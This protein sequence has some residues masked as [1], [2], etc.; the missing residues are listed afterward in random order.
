MR[1]SIGRYAVGALAVGGASAALLISG[2]LTT[3]SSAASNRLPAA[4]SP[5]ATFRPYTPATRPKPSNQPR[6]AGKAGA[7]NP[8]LHLVNAP[9]SG[10]VPGSMN[11]L[12]NG[13]VLIHE[14]NTR[15]WE[16][17]TPDS[18][19][20]YVNGTWSS[21]GST[22][23]G[24]APLY[25]ASQV[26]PTGKLIIEGGEYNGSNSE[27]WTTLGA[28][29]N[30]TTNS[31]A[32]VSPPSTWRNMG[33]AQSVMLPTRT[34]GKMLLAHPFADGSGNTGRD[35]AILNGN[36]SWT[37]I[38]GTGK[39]DRNDEEGWTLLPNNKVL[40]VD[41]ENNWNG[42]SGSTCSPCTS[43]LFNRSTNTWSATGTVPVDLPS[44]V[45]PSGPSEEMGPVVMRPNG[46]AFAI[47]GNDATASYHVGT[48]TWTAGPTLANNY[49]S[50]DGSASIL[51]NGDVLLDASPGVFNSPTH[52]YVSNG[53]TMTQVA[54][55][56][57]APSDSSYVTRMIVLPTGQVMVDDGTGDIEIFNQDLTYNASWAPTISSVSST[58]LAPGTTY[59]VSGTQLSGRSGGAAYGDDNQS[60]TNYPLVR[61]TNTSTGTVTYATTSG[62]SYAITSGAASQTS[63]VVPA[64][65]PAGNYT[66]QVVAN[67]IPSTGTAVTVS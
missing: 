35:G 26:L 33:D 51:P 64:G 47:G 27:V 44:Y 55:T 50:A 8:W 3:A 7:A 56:T 38:P 31:W 48:G 19:G 53:T 13:T 15:T 37:N 52:F 42:S 36:L 4:S 46:T 2:S 17:L 21:A 60:A 20:S 59:T 14:D 25:Y 11:L 49:D 39:L 22:P 12:T 63:F 29:Y 9:P 61:L 54:D 67:G 1:A 28:I 32:S 41:I 45:G 62:F 57:N 6:Y 10:F 43:E 5:S 66:L 34:S 30:P 58:T 24:Y 65:T 40:T 18:T 23:A 16:K